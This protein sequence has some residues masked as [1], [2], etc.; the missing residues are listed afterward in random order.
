M[1]LDL[2][3]RRGQVRHGHAQLL[4]RMEH[5]EGMEHIEVKA[6]HLLR[7]VGEVA[8]PEKAPTLFVNRMPQAAA[9]HASQGG[10]FKTLLA[11]G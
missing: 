11:S 7:A 5:I 10:A 4:S 2:L 1:T 3:A 6:L 8:C 9:R